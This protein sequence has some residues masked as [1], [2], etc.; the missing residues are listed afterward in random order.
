MP[1][2]SGNRD[3]N[4]AGRHVPSR[5]AGGEALVPLVPEICRA[6]DVEARVLTIDPP[7]GLIDPDDALV[8]DPGER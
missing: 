4:L 8:A 3:G 1:K 6:L 7:R 5:D 2:G